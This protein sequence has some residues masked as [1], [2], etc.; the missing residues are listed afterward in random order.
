MNYF[1]RLLFCLALGCF[2]LTLSCG[3]EEKEETTTETLTETPATT[4]GAHTTMG[5][6]G[7]C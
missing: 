3:E 4:C 1:K 6:I 5:F 7:A 2:A